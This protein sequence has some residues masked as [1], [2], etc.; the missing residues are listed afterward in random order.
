[1]AED[2]SN[3]DSNLPRLLWIGGCFMAGLA[4][5]WLKKE[6]GEDNLVSQFI[7]NVVEGMTGGDSQS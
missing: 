5:G 1:M 2:P 4:S 3:N 7:D 6:L